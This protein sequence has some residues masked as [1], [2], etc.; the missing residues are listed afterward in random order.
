[1]PSY[2]ISM[3]LRMYGYRE[4]T[5][6]TTR[7]TSEMVAVVKLGNGA[8]ASIVGYQTPE[9]PIPNCRRKSVDMVPATTPCRHVGMS[10]KKTIETRPQCH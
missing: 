10:K 2:N 8:G 6:V 9:E 5:S 3:L 4:T 1:M 7:R